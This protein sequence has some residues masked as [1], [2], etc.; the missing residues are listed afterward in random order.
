MQ[1]ITNTGSLFFVA[2]LFYRIPKEVKYDD[3]HCLPIIKDKRDFDKELYMFRTDLLSITRSLN[4][5]CKTI[6]QDG[7]R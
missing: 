6:G 3:V 2:F 5:V 1:E 4:I 7:L